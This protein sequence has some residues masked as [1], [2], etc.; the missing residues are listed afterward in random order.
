[1][2]HFKKQLVAKKQKITLL[3]NKKH[4]IINMVRQR[5]T[6][7]ELYKP[8]LCRVMA[9]I[10]EEEE[11]HYPRTLNGRSYFLLHRQPSLLWLV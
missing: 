10:E 6:L 7:E 5:K 1:V 9:F 4:N 3:H 8:Y 11:D 2:L